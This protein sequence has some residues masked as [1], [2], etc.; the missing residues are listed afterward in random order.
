MMS[1]MPVMSMMS[2]VMNGSWIEALVMPGI[3][4]PIIVMVMVAVMMLVSF[5][6]L[7]ADCSHMKLNYY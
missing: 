4:V 3:I 5:K 2:A 6:L 1:M 7:L